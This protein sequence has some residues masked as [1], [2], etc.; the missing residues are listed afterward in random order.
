MLSSL[1]LRFVALFPPHLQNTAKQFIKF[2][3]VGVIGAVV[4]FGSYNIMTRGLDWNSIF[5][6]AGYEIIAANLVSVFLAIMSNFVLNKY[7]TFEDSKGPV[8]KQ[9][10]GY[11]LLNAVTFVLNQIL[12]SFFTFR[13]PLIEAF[14]GSQKD[15]AAKALAI[16][17]ILFINF[18]GSKF[19]IF[20]RRT[21][22]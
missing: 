5:L 13:V 16:G 18:A 9:W 7:W 8:V 11:F 1:A 2:G 20:R 14:F 22:R 10:S 15:N 19:L 12:T 4:D 17:F 6:V 3:V 21:S